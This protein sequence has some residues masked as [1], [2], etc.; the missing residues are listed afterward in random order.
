MCKTPIQWVPGTI[1]PGVK[2]PGLEA[3]H[4]PSSSTEVKNDRTVLPQPIC[5]HG[6]VLN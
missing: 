4:S 2:R 3:E 1:Y 5:L 6:V